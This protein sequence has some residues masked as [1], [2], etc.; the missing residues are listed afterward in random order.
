MPP[1][2]ARFRPAARCST[3]RHRARGCA[4]SRA[5]G[6]SHSSAAR[7]PCQRTEYD[8]GP[9][10]V[11]ASRT[12]SGSPRH[13]CGHAPSSATSV[14]LAS[15]SALRS[16]L[17]NGARPAAACRRTSS[18]DA[19]SD[20]RR[21]ALRRENMPRRTH[22]A[23][24]SSSKPQSSS[25]D[26]PPP[27]PPSTP[28]P[29]SRSCARA[30]STAACSSG[31]GSSTRIPRSSWARHPRDHLPRRRGTVCGV[32]LDVRPQRQ[33]EPQPRPVRDREQERR[34]E[35]GRPV[36]A[37]ARTRR[38]ERR[39]CVTICA[40]VASSVIA[41][42]RR[43]TEAQDRGPA[44]DEDGGAVDVDVRGAAHDEGDDERGGRLVDDLHHGRVRRGAV[45]VLHRVTPGHAHR[46]CDTTGMPS[47]SD[48]RTATSSSGRCHR[49]S[50]PIH[51]PSSQ[52]ARSGRTLPTPST[53]ADPVAAED[54]NKVARPAGS[55]P[56]PRRSHRRPCSSG[57]A[58]RSMSSSTRSA[59]RRPS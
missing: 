41:H 28:A 29:P 23:R 6:T 2:R 35:S 39:R 59:G 24:A 42:H 44:V 45:H 10:F 50:A 17:R 32:D 49:S 16:E 38:R 11:G 34:L 25:A 33:E 4:R 7:S 54:A 47:R 13:S 26:R 3:R 52:P 57:F 36:A 12:S 9:S 15:T 21:A 27:E 51:Q 40:V 55:V 14:P 53:D 19:R 58:S 20:G 5:A 18:Q 22:A 37:A 8:T 46:R 31:S 30:E 1:V 56:E 43:R 48:W